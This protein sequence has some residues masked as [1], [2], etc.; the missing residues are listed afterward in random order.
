MEHLGLLGKY[1]G[2]GAIKRRAVGVAHGTGVDSFSKRMILWRL[3]CI[4]HLP[5]RF[6]WD[7]WDWNGGGQPQSFPFFGAGEW[8]IPNTMVG[9]CMNTLWGVGCSLPAFRPCPQSPRCASG[10]S[11]LTSCPGLPSPRASFLSPSLLETLHP[12]LPAPIPFLLTQR[13]FLQTPILSLLYH[14]CSIIIRILFWASLVPKKN[15]EPPSAT[16]MAPKMP[17]LVPLL[18]PFF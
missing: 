6:S 18:R 3:G 15:P 14:Y 12:T 7:T 4:W 10:V 17:P 11:P 16:L 13:K 1:G 8:S 9:G 5:Q 2:G